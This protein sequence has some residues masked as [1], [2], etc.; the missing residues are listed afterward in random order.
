MDIVAYLRVST[1]EQGQSGLGL[2][3][4]EQ[5]IKLFAAYNNLNIIRIVREVVSGKY[6]LDMRPVLKEAIYF[7]NKHKYTLVVSSLDRLSRSVAFITSLMETKLDFR[8]ADI[9]LNADPML[10]QVKAVVAE[11]ERKRI[12][13]R[14]KAALE[15]LK[16]QGVQLG[17]PHSNDIIIG[18]VKKLGINSA[19]KLGG[20]A[21]KQKARDYALT[22]EPVLDMMLGSGNTHTDIAK[23]LT[24]L[25]VKTQR[26]CDW[27]AT[28]VRNVLNTLKEIRN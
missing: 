15:Q 28:G 14:T 12:G 10:L 18:D 24:M 13:I 23:K 5:N 26:G 19:S 1:S 22:L 27:T 3:A 25:G 20:N 11:E 17:N 4:Q 7:C 6:S 16:K 8:V 2:E 9:G 21:T